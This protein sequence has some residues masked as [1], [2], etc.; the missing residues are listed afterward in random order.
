[1]TTRNIENAL[2][3][4]AA[5][6]VLIGVTFA[7]RSA[8]ADHEAVIGTTAVAI[9]TA[10]DQSIAIAELAQEKAASSAAEAVVAE[11]RLDLDIRL[12]DPIFRLGARR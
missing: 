4:A 7:A 12:L 9:H 1:M 10:C 11:T 3:L 8:L 6:V 2:A 5:L